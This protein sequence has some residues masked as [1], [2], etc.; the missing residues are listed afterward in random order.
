M[1]TRMLTKKSLLLFAFVTLATLATPPLHAQNPCMQ[2]WNW[3]KQKLTPSLEQRRTAVASASRF[4]S[5]LTFRNLHII[6]PGSLASYLS[7]GQL[8]N[9]HQQNSLSYGIVTWAASTLGQMAVIRH[10]ETSSQ[11]DLPQRGIACLISGIVAAVLFRVATDYIL[12]IDPASSLMSTSF[13]MISLIA[14]PIVTVK[15]SYLIGSAAQRLVT[16]GQRLF[17]K[18]PG[19]KR[20]L[21][22]GSISTQSTTDL[23]TGEGRDFVAIIIEDFPDEG[24]SSGQHDHTA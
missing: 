4:V 21:L 14:G 19:V 11:H 17:R 5:D 23:E 24:E 22:D 13:F 2:L 1:T 3:L 9:L 16:L 20:E 6:L 18:S 15:T 8:Q 12:V 7:L 10:L